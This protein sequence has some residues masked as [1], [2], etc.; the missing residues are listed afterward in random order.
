MKKNIKFDTNYFFKLLSMEKFWTLIYKKFPSFYVFNVNKRYGNNKE[1]KLKIKGVTILFSIEDFYSRTWIYKRCDFNKIHEENVI[2]VLAKYLK[3]SKCFVDVGAHIGYYTFLASKL[4]SSGNVFSF[5]M[6][7]INYRLLEKN[8]KLNK[9]K[10]A[11]IYNLAISDS[12]GVIN[13]ARNSGQPDPTLSSEEKS[14]DIKNGESVSIKTV[15]LD[16]FFKNI[17]PKP[18]IIKIDVEGAEMQVLKGMKQLLKKEDIKIFLEVHPE[19]LSEFGLSVK[20]VISFLM[21]RGYNVFEFQDFRKE[22]EGSGLSKIGRD[23]QLSKNTML[24]AYK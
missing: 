12:T 13:Y 23:A 24:F 18:D 11:H 4:M 6:D 19:R 15:S 17:D 3:S 1:F 2:D 10:N 20:K 5:E 9:S 14:L 16:D 22:H 7:E 8:F 21:D